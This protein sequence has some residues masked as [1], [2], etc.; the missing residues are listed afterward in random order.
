[1]G[2]GNAVLYIDVIYVDLR[3]IFEYCMA[4]DSALSLYSQISL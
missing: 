3:V 2:L 1:M 4:I